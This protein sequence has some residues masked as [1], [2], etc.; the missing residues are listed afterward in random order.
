MTKKTK[1]KQAGKLRIGDQW[2]AI[3]IIAL[4]QNNPLKAIA[5]FTENSIDAKASQVTIIRGKE[6]GEQYLRIIDDGEGLPKDE[7]GLPNFKY[8]ATHICDS[9]K[10]QLKKTGINGL[11]GEFGI[12]LLSFWT[13]GERLKLISSGTD[14][15][16]YTMHMEKGNPGYTIHHRKLLVPTKGT[17]L[18]ISPMLSA[19]KHINGDKIQRYLASELRDRIRKSGVSIR[20]I[21]RL[22]RKEYQVEPRQFTGQLLHHLRLD[23][24]YGQDIYLE[25]YL[26]KLSNENKVGLYRS[27]TRVVDSITRL[28]RFSQEPWT[29][30][31]LEGMIDVPFLN[32]TPGTRDGIIHDDRLAQLE[33]ALRPVEEQLN[34]VIA[35]Q[36]H[37]EEEQ[38][39]R[40]LLKTVR[41]AFKEALLMLPRDD[42]E[43]F[44]IEGEKKKQTGAGR[45]SDSGRNEESL[46]VDIEADQAGENKTAG[47]RQK[48][49]FEFAG[50]LH[51]LMISPATAT[52]AVNSSKRFRIVAR[53]RQNKKIEDVLRCQWQLLEGRAAWD[54]DDQEFINL[55]ALGEP[56]LIKLGVTVTQREIVKQAE[57]LITVTGELFDEHTGGRPADQKG[58]P[59]YTFISAIGELWRS[60]YHQEQNLILI[61]NS[62]KDFVYAAKSKSGKV[63]YICRLFAKE[64]V[65]FNFPGLKPDQLLDRMIELSMYTEENL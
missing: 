43:W 45:S 5:E 56:G 18:V 34:Q 53:D 4:S 14:D 26:N 41:N 17:E 49:F 8:V 36:Q 39:S 35:E 58:L 7:N 12:G 54:A 28:D 2:N 15:V 65:L 46:G 3:T 59:A 63:R 22:A 42:Y 47:S 61:N 6:R 37:A 30:G 20:V 9:I 23:D 38:T 24:R 25:L 60:R 64:L 51:K 55:T 19:T 44:E 32:L 29:R 13:V 33:E 16:T 62:H 1:S 57:A 21:D 31:Y 40:Q 10:R 52:M 11:Q 27:G 48:Q 50:P